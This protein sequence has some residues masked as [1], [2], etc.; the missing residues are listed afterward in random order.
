MISHAE[1]IAAPVARLPEV[2]LTPQ[3]AEDSYAIARLLMDIDKTMLTFVGMEGNVTL[4]SAVYAALVF[5]L[6]WMV[7]RIIQWIIVFVINRLGDKLH[8]DLYINMRKAR[9]FSKIA[10]IVSPVIFL[11]L[12]QF[13]L[14]YKSTLYIW[15][16]RFSWIYVAYIISASLCILT[17]A[18]WNHIDERS[19]KRKL[20]LRG[21]VQ[22][23]KGMIWIIFAIVVL[24]IIMDKSPVALLTGFGVFASV[25]MLV[26]KDSILGVVAGVQLSENDSLHVGDW[27]KVPGTEANGTVLEV[28]LIQIKVLN[29]D[30][31]IT[32]IPPYNLV[33]GS[34][35]NYRNMQDSNTRRIQRSMM[36]DADSVIPVNDKLLAEFSEIP[37]MKKWIERKLAQRAAGAECDV[38]NPEGLADGSM[39][40]N[41]GMFRAYMKMW[42]DSNT[43][44][45]MG[46]ICY[47]FVTTLPQTANGIPLQI[48]CFTNT[49]D[50]LQYE[51]IMAGIFEHMSVMLC[52]FHLYVY[53]NTSGRDTVVDGW[54]SAGKAPDAVFG[55]PYPFFKNPETFGNV[56]SSVISP[57]RL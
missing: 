29:W 11:I 39:E 47:C 20:P 43:H 26:F 12:I 50:W 6:A 37:M 32:T 48:Y 55:L 34:F 41:L 3:A 28:S 23:V 22:L 30:K 46:D 49:S 31:T 53:E 13:T 38:N 18:V 44:I 4:F 14:S 2:A 54:M 42:L 25:L 15:L 40:T 5:M 33:S 9:F 35:T 45:A 24:S 17:E 7:G 36:I 27:I 21:L 19:N 10:R 56:G 16:T 1:N 57:G 52:K 51:S 8:N